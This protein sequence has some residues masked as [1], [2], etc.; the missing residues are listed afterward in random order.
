MLL[1]LGLAAGCGG[2]SEQPNVVLISVDMLR[3]DHLSCYGYGRPTSPN[4]DRL[5]NEGVRYENHFASSPWTLPSHASIFT[6]LPDS[7]HGCTDTDRAL[8]PS[9][10]TLAERFASAG[11]ATAGFFAGPYLHPAFGLGQGFETYE[12]CAAY[13]A[14]L[15]AR[16]PSEWAMDEGVMRESHEDV[17]NE[18]VH[19]AVTRWMSGRPEKPF[20]LFIH[21]W[22]VHFDFVPPPPYDKAF[23]PDY[24]GWVD[25]RN[26]FFDPRYGPE[27]DARDLEHLL[28][29]YDG[30]IAWT[31]SIVGRIRGEL[32]K[33]GILEDTVFAL[34]SDHGTEFFEHGR[35]GHR[36]T[37]YD[38]VIRTPL[39]IRFP[40]KL[41]AAR[42]VSG[43][44]R[45][46]DVG[47]TLLE[48]AGLPAPNDVLGRS[49]VP[50]A[51]SPEAPPVGRAV[52]ELFSAGNN[53]RAVRTRRW[54]LF[55]WIGT[56]N[57]VYFDLEQD[58]AERSPRL[59][60]ESELGKKAVDGY[61]AEIEGMNAFMARHPVPVSSGSKSSS[62]PPEVME[63]LKTQG[64][65]GGES[66]PDPK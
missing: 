23:D 32:E 42:R 52:S 21:L 35:K 53:V 33:A 34:T 9:A 57:H 61:E 3:P 17:T 24:K 4:I 25:G 46:L 26:F 44:T 48:L 28:A 64:Y 56:P 27:M 45:G 66:R 14:K 55:D 51:H 12:D 29:L 43:L 59:D 31:D 1:A 16:P 65:V 15:A 47:P 39:I 41:P 19:A 30:E 6:S 22:D 58:P 60:F 8:A 20:F 54:K 18:R 62:P 7:L 11:Y 38:E 49:L 37:L 50:L 63:R 5:A 40:P 10:L 13:A 36:Q 2:G